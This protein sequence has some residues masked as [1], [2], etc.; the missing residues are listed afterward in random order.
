MAMRLQPGK[1][2][3]LAGKTFVFGGKFGYGVENSLKALAEA[4]RGT[5]NDD[6]SDKVD[7]LVLAD[8]SIGKAIQ[9]KAVTLNA[10]GA[11]IQVIDA[12]GFKKLAELTDD[13]ILALIRS[14]D[15]ETYAKIHGP[16]HYYARLQ[17]AKHVF[18]SEELSG[19]KLKNVALDDIQFDAC[20]FV[21]AELD[22]VYIA[23]ASD[24]DFSKA[25]GDSSHIGSLPGSRF[26]K[27]IFK[28]CHLQGDLSGADFTGATL[29]ET[30]LGDGY[31]GRAGT[32]SHIGVVF[33][34]SNLPSTIF[35]GLHLKSPD[36]RSA[37]LTGAR[38]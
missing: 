35:Q 11:T 12:D 30:S 28:R 14:G 10:K 4:Q 31:F 21:R 26:H 29:A 34:K 38:F 37:N 1:L 24:C 32:T 16:A 22:H 20:R 18:H 23:A 15:S 9:K 13:E 19:V 2:N 6:V 8:L 27:S 33:N 7:F 5:V 36:F 3:R 25:V 17:A